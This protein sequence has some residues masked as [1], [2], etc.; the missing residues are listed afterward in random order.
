MAV[1]NGHDDLLEEEAGVV[2]FQPIAAMRRRG[3]QVS[4]S[5]S[6]ERSNRL[7]YPKYVLQPYLCYCQRAS[8][9]SWC[10]SSTILMTYLEAA[11]LPKM[12]KKGASMAGQEYP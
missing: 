4:K 8:F 12:R 2:L 5:P 1:V 6:V 7:S 9:C 3:L 10:S 11:R